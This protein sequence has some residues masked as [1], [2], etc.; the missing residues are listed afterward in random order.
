MRKV[1]VIPLIFLFLSCFTEPRKGNQLDSINEV[2][3]IVYSETVNA[4]DKN[5][6]EDTKKESLNNN[7]ELSD[8]NNEN[9]IT[10]IVRELNK[11]S[12]Q[13]GF[14]NNI[15]ELSILNEKRSLM[16]FN[17]VE[18]KLDDVYAVFLDKDY[19]DG[20]GTFRVAIECEK[21]ES[22]SNCLYDTSRSDYILSTIFPLQTKE[23]CLRYVE[24]FNRLDK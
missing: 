19:N 14:P 13:S 20:Y 17:T 10:S 6:E 23:D 18:F 11:I 4:E 12:N 9:N 1:L 2:N 21:R 15:S 22:G 16:L 8:I 7:N 3:N 5:I 24:L